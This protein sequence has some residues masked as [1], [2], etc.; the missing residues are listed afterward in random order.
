M[1]YMFYPNDAE[2]R[3]QS[4]ALS[5]AQTLV[6]ADGEDDSTMF[7]VSRGD[8]RRLI[9]VPP[10]DSVRKNRVERTKRAYI[11]GELLNAVYLMHKFD[12][13]PSIGRAIYALEAWSPTSGYGDG[14]K[15]VTSES[16]IRE[17]WREFSPVA[18]F[19]SAIR[20]N[21]SYPFAPERLAFTSEHF[22][23]FLAVAAGFHQFAT[24]FIPPRARPAI[25]IVD[26]AV[27]WAPP[28]DIE[29]RTLQSDRF[30]DRLELL[31]RR[32]KAPTPHLP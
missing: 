10:P 27:A 6:G 17:C 7:A 28:S 9:A 24:T 15:M 8:L 21:R 29:P 3:A 32:Y 22:S 12:L 31:L 19:W 23:T 14:S 2:A 25:P 26:P 1:L 16:A 13:Q 30:P 5:R 11:A 4:L 18:H 20:I